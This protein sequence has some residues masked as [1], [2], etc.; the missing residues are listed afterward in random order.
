MIRGLIT[1]TEFEEKIRDLRISH[2]LYHEAEWNTKQ[3]WME[4]T[5]P[6]KIDEE[7]KDQVLRFLENEKSVREGEEMEE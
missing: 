1:E 6:F 7:L 4:R 3:D 5:I 2:S